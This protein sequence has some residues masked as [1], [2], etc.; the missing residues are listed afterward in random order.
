MYVSIMWEA[1]ITVLSS[2]VAYFY[3]Q[4]RFHWLQYVGI[5]LAMAAMALVHYGA[6]LNK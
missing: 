6:H 4:E 1:M 3:F 2:L 5:I